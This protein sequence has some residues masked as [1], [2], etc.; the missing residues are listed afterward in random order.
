MV[1]RCLDG[2]PVDC[3]TDDPH[4]EQK[5]LKAF[6]KRVSVRGIVKYNNKGNPSRVMAEQIRV[7]RSDSELFPLSKIRGTL[8]EHS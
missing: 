3:V 8:N 1:Y 2:L 6:R 5:A 7:F 4:L